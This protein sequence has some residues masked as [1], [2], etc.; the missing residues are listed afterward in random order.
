MHRFAC[1]LLVDP[2]GW[3][4]LQERDE[5][6]VIDPERWGLVGGHVED[7]EEYEPAAYRELAE[8]TGF[9]LAPGTLRLFGEIE[10][11]HE[12]YGTLD[13]TQVWYA[14]TDR[15]DADVVVGEGRQIVFVE[16]AAARAKDLT[17]SAAIVV[18]AFL[19]SPEYREL[20]A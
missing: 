3:V 6:P 18:P 5:H 8:E 14:A 15:T 1:A 13:T 11:F 16:P 17:A 7:G 2:R 12:A 9:D 20:L 10:V 19:D 4:L